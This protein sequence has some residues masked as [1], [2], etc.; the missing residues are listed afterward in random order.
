LVT[1]GGISYTGNAFTLS[2]NP[3]IGTAGAAVPDPFATTPTHATL[4]SG[5][6]AS[7]G[8][9]ASPNPPPQNQT[10]NYPAG[11]MFCGGLRVQNATANLAPG[12]YWITD[13]NLDIRSNGHV[14]CAA[15]TG[16]TGVT[17]ILTA[18]SATGQIGTVMMN[19]N[20]SVTLTAPST[21]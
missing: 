13:G 6:P 18:G 19:S 7:P 2:A 5:M 9:C 14:T 21:G 10:T 3:L 17:I 16:G 11:S 8:G 15:C 12:V 20:S 4:I 1:P